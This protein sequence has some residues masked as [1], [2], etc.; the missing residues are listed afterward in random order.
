MASLP[1][2][3]NAFT[4]IE[5]LV[6]IA[7]IAIL[8]GLLLP[9]VQKVREAAAR[10]SCSNN[11]KQ[12]SLACHNYGSSNN[13]AFPPFYNYN[14]FSGETQV[15]VALLPHIEQQAIY[16]S[17]GTNPLNLQIAGPSIGHRATVKTYMCPSDPTIGNGLLQG[18]WASGSY[19]ANFQVFGNPGV[20]N[21][22]WANA[23][24]TPNLKSTFNDGTS[25]TILFA[26]Q[27]ALRPAGHWNLW[28]H[29]GWN[30]SYAPIFAYGSADGTVPY[31]AGMDTPSGVVGVAS[32]PYI[33]VRGNPGSNSGDMNRAMSAHTGSMQVGLADGSVRG[34]SSGIS[35]ATWW[36]ACTPQF[37]DLLGSDW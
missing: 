8:I 22:S 20:G 32:M 33:G 5:L 14:A 3:R 26:E 23:V 12:I 13:D 30:N 37:G 34:I 27:F 1:A 11:L 18:D 4:L 2:K 17:F 29:G 9:A 19:V 7:I 6:V 10:M 21:N 28:A 36:A 16:N 25:N 15:F 24:G 35:P 31:T